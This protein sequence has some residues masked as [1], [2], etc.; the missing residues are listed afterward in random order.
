[1]IVI[2]LPISVTLFEKVNTVVERSPC[3]V[4]CC[5]VELLNYTD[6]TRKFL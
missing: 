1:M 4:P 3:Y 2:T 6:L 5:R